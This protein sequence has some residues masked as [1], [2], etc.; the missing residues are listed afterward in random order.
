MS[1]LKAPFMV[2]TI[3]TIS[4]MYCLGWNERNG[5]NLSLILTS[6]EMAPYMSELKGERVIALDFDATPLKGICFLV[7]G[8]GKYFKNVEFNPN[9]NL[10]IVKITDDGDAQVLWGFE[11]DSRYTSEFPSHLMSHI[12]RLKVDKN[13]KIVL[14]AHPT[15]TLAMT[16]TEEL[17][18]RNFS[19]IFWQSATECIVV[20]PEGVGLLPWMVCG[21]KEIGIETAKKIKKYRSCIWTNHG[22]FASGASIDECF[23]LMETI[24]KTA[25]VYMIAKPCGIKNLIKDSELKDL[26]KTFGLT[27]NPEFID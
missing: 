25:M 9:E 4:N 6:D 19:R 10:G 21:T 22:V 15:Y 18:E 17:S 8:T 2:D 23:G 12:E 3:R 1:I 13:H 16:L 27:L 11:N 20:F 14:H 24:E 26:A 5:G 7:T